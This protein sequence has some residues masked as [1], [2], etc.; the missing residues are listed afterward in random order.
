M[1]PSSKKTR[2]PKLKMVTRQLIWG[3]TPK[4]FILQFTDIKVWSFYILTAQKKTKVNTHLQTKPQKSHEQDIL[5]KN[6]QINRLFF[7]SHE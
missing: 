6:L 3:Q 1:S 2:N 7:A 4:L 5:S